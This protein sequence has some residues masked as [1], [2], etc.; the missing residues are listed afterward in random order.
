MKEDA[1]GARRR[2]GVFLGRCW[3]EDHKENHGGHSNHDRSR[4]TRAE[5]VDATVII[6]EGVRS[7]FGGTHDG[8]EGAKGK[9]TG[10]E[11]GLERFIARQQS[12]G[13]VFVLPPEQQ[14]DV[15]AELREFARGL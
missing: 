12:Y 6:E 2:A 5:A 3:T 8:V 10:G 7:Q 9:F 4:Q 13:R 11:A 1:R 14:I 15:K